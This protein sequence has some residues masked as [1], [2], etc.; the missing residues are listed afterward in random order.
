MVTV[1]TLGES[2]LRLSTTPNERLRHLSELR[3]VFGGAEANVAHNLAMLGNKVRYATKVPAN[4]LAQNIYYELNA[5]GV[6]TQYIISKGSGRLG[7]YYV[8]VGSDLRASTVVYDRAFSE[9][10]NMKE[11]EWDLESLFDGIDIFHTTGITLGLSKF[12]HE[13]LLE[14]IKFAKSKGIKVVFDMN[15]RSGLWSQEEA[16]QAFVKVLPYVDVLSA[17]KL[18]AKHFMDIEI[19][20]ESNSENFLEQIAQKYPNVEAIFGTNRISMTPNAYQLTGFYYDTETKKVFH[21]KKHQIQ[22]VVDRVGAGDA[23]AA[24]IIDGIIKHRDPQSVVEFA[25]A[26]SVLKHTIFGDANWFTTE[27]VEQFMKTSGGNIIR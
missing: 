6:D 20:D 13:Y 19:A 12:W 7:S 15:Y 3:V 21:S 23:Y 16:K 9:I 10:A 18:D 25:M 14:L 4:E 1:L 17:N 27:Q 8:E 24:G 11:R 2:L 5:V 26:S 22:Y